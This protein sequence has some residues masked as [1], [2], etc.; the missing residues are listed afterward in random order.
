MSFVQIPG[1]YV[2]QGRPDFFTPS[3][4]GGPESIYANPPANNQTLGWDSNDRMVM[5]F[6][7]YKLGKD[8]WNQA[9]V[10]DSWVFLLKDYDL[11]SPKIRK[12]V[13]FTNS[14][15]REK[16][17]LLTLQQVNFLLASAGETLKTVEDVYK[18]IHP[19]GINTTAEAERELPR[20]VM[21]VIVGGNA[22]STFN[23]WGNNY[24]AMA[25]A[26]FL[27]KRVKIP[28]D[29]SLRFSLSANNTDIE[30]IKAESKA[31]EVYQIVP[32]ASVLGTEPMFKKGVEGFFRVGTLVQPSALKDVATTDKYDNKNDRI[33]RDMPELMSK[34]RMV[35][36]FVNIF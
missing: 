19:L 13:R 2:G 7:K 34:S 36:M 14:S 10:R 26:Y 23:L 3:R 9:I 20:P 25:K 30:H 15:I 16:S 11:L 8:S 6:A 4:I 21:N 24:P 33:S 32:W 12:H 27:I 31:T 35:K 29:E 18:A 22:E 17:V 5:G 1:P 28:S